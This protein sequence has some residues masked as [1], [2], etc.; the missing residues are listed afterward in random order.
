MGGGDGGENEAE[1]SPGGKDLRAGQRGAGHHAR[2]EGKQRERNVSG[3]A[4]IKA[5]GNVPER[6]RKRESGEQEGRADKPAMLVEPELR[7]E[8]ERVARQTE[9][10]MPATE[11]NG[12]RGEEAGSASSW[13]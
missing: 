8:L 12:T 1:G 4:A 6:E 13:M 7:I 5:A 11:S 3:G 2:T 9:R 10:P